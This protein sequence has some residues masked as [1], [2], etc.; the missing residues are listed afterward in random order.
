MD[1]TSTGKH[2]HSMN[3]SAVWKPGNFSSVV[4]FA[5]GHCMIFSKSY[6]SRGFPLILCI[7]HPLTSFLLQGLDILTLLTASSQTDVIHL[8]SA[9]HPPQKKCWEKQSKLTSIEFFCC[10]L[11]STSPTSSWFSY[12]FSTLLPLSVVGTDLF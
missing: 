11:F 12:S 7:S 6:M 4:G 9:P 10:V 1:S 2:C 8:R 5:N 3:G